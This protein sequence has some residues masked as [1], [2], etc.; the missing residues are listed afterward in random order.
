MP[1]CIE[2]VS[3]EGLAELLL[4]LVYRIKVKVNAVS[5]VL[6]TTYVAELLLFVPRLYRYVSLRP[7]NAAVSGRVPT[8]LQVVRTALWVEARRNN[9][10]EAKDCVDMFLSDKVR[11]GKVHQ[12][13]IITK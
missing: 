2:T 10:D 5:Y 1:H 7:Y 12:Y 3:D 6:R 13:I 9:N 4:S 11:M 8:N